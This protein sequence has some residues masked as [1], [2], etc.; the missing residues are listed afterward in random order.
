MISALMSEWCL[1][2]S[3]CSSWTWSFRFC[4]S[5]CR[6]WGER[7]S[8]CR[9]SCRLGTR[10]LAGG[11]WGG[12]AS[13]LGGLCSTGHCTLARRGG[14]FPASGSQAL[15]PS[16]GRSPHG[17]GSAPRRLSRHPLPAA[18]W[19][20]RTGAALAFGPATPTS[21][22][23]GKGSWAPSAP[24][25]LGPL[26]AWEENARGCR[27]GVPELLPTSQCA[28][29]PLSPGCARTPGALK[30]TDAKPSPRAGEVHQDV[31][32]AG[33][34]QTL[35][36]F[37]RWTLKIWSNAQSPVSGALAHPSSLGICPDSPR[38][39]SSLDW[40]AKVRP[41]GPH[42]KPPLPFRP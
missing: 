2:R 1:V 21:F 9:V 19:C 35:C 42:P 14:A 23:P 31:L 6:R 18:S 24:W 41:P 7:P 30:G 34:Q 33:R 15:P 5:T 37:T 4:I 8:E 36:S 16:P 13:R 26:P 28:L 12:M 10:R 3:R 40:D 32:R 29:G 17:G 20:S 38:V 27:G 39:S 25:G 11:A 22:P